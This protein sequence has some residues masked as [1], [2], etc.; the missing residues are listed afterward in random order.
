MFGCLP[1]FNTQNSEEEVCHISRPSNVLHNI[2]AIID[3]KTNKIVGLPAVWEKIINDTIPVQKRSTLLFAA[4]KA[5]SFMENRID[6]N[7]NSLTAQI[8]E[9]EENSPSLPDRKKLNLVEKKVISNSP[10]YKN[11]TV[12]TH[13]AR[14]NSEDEIFEEMKKICFHEDSNAFAKYKI[15]QKKIGQGASG[16]FL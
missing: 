11:I 6:S 15:V 8:S 1:G 7:D 2:H 16:I 10:G 3:P 9:F 12:K 5:V 4:I 13:L 14:I